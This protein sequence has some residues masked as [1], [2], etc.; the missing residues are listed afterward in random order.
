M[1]THT[2]DATAPDLG[3]KDAS[4]ADDL[5]RMAPIYTAVV[6]VELLVLLGLW[7]FQTYF[8]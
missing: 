4:D 8:G 1:S 5:R 3:K 2:P 7:W 6:V